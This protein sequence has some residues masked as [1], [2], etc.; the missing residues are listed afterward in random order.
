MRRSQGAAVARTPEQFNIKFGTANRLIGSLLLASFGMNAHADVATLPGLSN[1]ELA[2]GK[3][4]D[5]LVNNMNDYVQS[6]GRLEPLQ[7]DLLTRCSNLVD[8]ANQILTGGE[9]TFTPEDILKVVHAIIPDEVGV[10]SS[11]FTDTSQAQFSVLTSRLS[12]LRIAT[13]MP[14]LSAL[15]PDFSDAQGGMASADTYSR[16]SAFANLGY[17]SGDKDAT[18]EELGFDFDSSNL[19]MGVDYKFTPD[20]IGGVALAILKSSSDVDNNAGDY[21]TDGQ[22][23]S[24]YGTY[25][26]D[27]YYFDAVLNYGLYDYDSKRNVTY[28]DNGGLLTYTINGDTEGDEMSLSLGGGYNFYKGPWNSIAFARLDYL[29][30][31]IDGYDEND[32]KDYSMHIGTMDVDSL[33]V[34]VGGQVAYTVST[35]FGVLVPYVGAELHKEF[36]DDS[37]D[38]EATYLYDPTSTKLVFATD[39]PDKTFGNISLGSNLVLQGGWQVFLNIDSIVGLE[40]VSNQTITLGGRMEF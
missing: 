35:S 8:A 30:A 4:I 23:L 32:D 12:Q 38:I 34:V 3:T 36:K 5:Q 33:Q 20:I 1:V 24:L 29:T 19:T 39:S 6:G 16:L 13:G 2:A 40:D 10:V 28:V 31:T 17:G 27:N 22:T 18:R 21:D 26:K 15:G 25:Y 7:Q 14:S 37:I 11:G 9:T